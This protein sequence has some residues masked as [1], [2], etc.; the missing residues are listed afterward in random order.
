[1]TPHPRPL[2]D[3]LFGHPQLDLLADRL[4][5]MSERH[6]TRPAATEILGS[7]NARIETCGSSSC[8]NVPGTGRKSEHATANAVDISGFRLGDGRLINIKTHW[9]NGGKDG[10]FMTRVHKGACRI[11]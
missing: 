11:F 3:P 5:Y 7:P 10:A 2:A 8:R 4:L 6:V 1:M 9:A